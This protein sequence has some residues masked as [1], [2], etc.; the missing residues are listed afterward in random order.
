MEPATWAPVMFHPVEPGLAFSAW[1]QEAVTP[2]PLRAVAGA[3]VGEG[4]GRWVR[5]AAWGGA[6]L[7]R[8]ASRPPATAADAATA[9]RSRAA[10]LAHRGLGAAWRGRPPRA[11]RGSDG[12]GPWLSTGEP[13]W[14]ASAAQVTGEPLEGP[15]PGVG[16]RLGVVGGAGVAVEAVAGAGV[17]VDLPGYLG[18]LGKGPAQG[19][20]V[21]HRDALV[22]VPEQAQPGGLQLCRPVDEGREPLRAGGDDAPAVEADRR[23]QRAVGGEQE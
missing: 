21:G 6:G 11:G 4:L 23:P 17:A 3:A 16:R 22:G 20:H 13:R 2:R 9:T 7:E 10:Q 15:P 14:P 19:L 8:L 5:V 12:A 18:V 1:T